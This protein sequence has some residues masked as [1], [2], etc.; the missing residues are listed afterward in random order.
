M[1]HVHSH[2]LVILVG[3]MKDIY[4]PVWWYF[5]KTSYLLAL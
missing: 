4:L 5:S 1:Y 2:P 3:K